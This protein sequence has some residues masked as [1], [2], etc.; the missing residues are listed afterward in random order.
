MSECLS[1]PDSDGKG[2]CKLF[3]T[4]LLPFRKLSCASVYT[5]TSAQSP[6]SPGGSEPL[7]REFKALS[8]TPPPAP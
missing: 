7:G 8:T 2:P 1:I 6:P 5:N 3:S 4:V